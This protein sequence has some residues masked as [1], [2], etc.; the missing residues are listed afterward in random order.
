MVHGVSDILNNSVRLIDSGCSNRMT[1][2]KS[3][4]NDLDLSKKIVVRLG[5]GKKME[6]AGKGTVSLSTKDGKTKLLHGVQYIPGLVHNLLSVGQL[7]ASGYSVLFEHECCTIKDNC[8]GV[9]LAKVQR[10]ENNM[11]PLEL[12][13]V[14]YANA[15]V[16]CDEVSSLWHR[17]YGHLNFRSLKLLI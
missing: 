14:G 2:H 16:R 13:A 12:S 7:N 15:V 11:F 8:T 4:F 9:Q 5:D 17:R 1:G 10:L 3:L 6:V